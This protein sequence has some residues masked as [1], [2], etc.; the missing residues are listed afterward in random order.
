ML[1]PLGRLRPRTRPAPAR[2]GEK[3]LDADKKNDYSFFIP[4]LSDAALDERRSH[5]L[6]A[7]EICFAR[8]GF[9][10]TTIADVR[11][12]ARV[13]T[14]A[15]YTYFRNKEEM[16]RAILERA[17]DDRKRRLESA[18][19]EIGTSAGPPLVLLEWA[20]AIFDVHGQHAARVDVNLWAEALRN[21]RIKKLAQAALRDATSAVS[22][23]VAPRLPFSGAAKSLDPASVASVL[24]ALFLGL[25]VETAVGMRLEPT[26][27]I[28][29][30]AT[31]F[32]DYLPRSSQPQMPPLER[33][34]R[35]RQRT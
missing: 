9:D 15:I 21:P 20:G 12:E 11:K 30:L 5:I 17:R 3:R 13:S 2:P 35:A 8:R 7:A 33:R 14:G 23:V 10:G 25:E 27:V 19:A 18:I 28:R 22:A 1:E 24:I 31:L 4:K 29:V 32:A 34:R 16:M 26:R 6:S